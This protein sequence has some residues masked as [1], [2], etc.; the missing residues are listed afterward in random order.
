MSA[1][2]PANGPD[3]RGFLEAAGRS[4]SEAQGELVGEALRPTAVAISEAQLEVKAAVAQGPDGTLSLQT[5]SVEEVKRSGVD[6]SLLST[7]R[8]SYVAVPSEA[9]GLPAV[10]TPA[11]ISETVRAR[12]DIAALDRILGGLVVD[13][14]F[15][16][17]RSRW[18]VAVRDPEGR[19]VRELILPD[20]P[21][22]GD[23][24]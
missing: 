7:L 3:L 6:A 16:P 14:I 24:A 18:L 1:E 22:E 12:P 19:L 20:Q 4:L 10:Q 13:P 17:D 21:E 23:D 8:I 9:A 5:L 15:V 11:D 2:T